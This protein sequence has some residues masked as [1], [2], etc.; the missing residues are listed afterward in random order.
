MEKCKQQSEFAVCV[1]AGRCF[2]D[3]LGLR[4][5]RSGLFDFRHF[6]RGKS[7][8]ISYLNL[9]LCIVFAP[10]SRFS[11]EETCSETWSEQNAIPFSLACVV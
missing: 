1:V 3:I 2:F 5:R 9:S 8:R 11:L 7:V 10:R 6:I 4:F